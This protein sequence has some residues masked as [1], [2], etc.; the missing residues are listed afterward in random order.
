MTMTK[1]LQHP[2]ND[3]FPLLDTISA[4]RLMGVSKSFLDKLRVRGEGPQYCKVGNR[5]RY[6]HKD[7]SHWL[8]G[9]LHRS[10]SDVEAA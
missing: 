2:A 4:S 1:T 8:D 6:R 3:P 10:T 9:R 5:V 7:I